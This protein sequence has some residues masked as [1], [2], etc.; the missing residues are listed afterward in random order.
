VFIVAGSAD[1]RQ[2]NVGAFLK[3]FA[4]EK[5]IFLYTVESAGHFFR[6]LNLDEAAEETIAFLDRLDDSH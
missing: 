6:D 4:D 3:R 1:E 2:P 5:K